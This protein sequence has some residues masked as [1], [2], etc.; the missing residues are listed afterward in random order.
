[1]TDQGENPFVSQNPGN[2]RPLSKQSGRAFHWNWKSDGDGIGVILYV[3]FDPGMRGA[4]GC[5]SCD[6]SRR[7]A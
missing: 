6:G 5:R 3:C 1:M 7:V 4:D 2:K